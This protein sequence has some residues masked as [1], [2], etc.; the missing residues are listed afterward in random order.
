MS[1][2]GACYELF[3]IGLHTPC[4]GRSPPSDQ[5]R[6]IQLEEGD[7]YSESIILDHHDLK[8]IKSLIKE[9]S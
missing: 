9:N 4:R 7:S 1:P 6:D 5:D 2:S 3:D 8:T